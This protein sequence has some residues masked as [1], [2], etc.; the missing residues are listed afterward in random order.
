MSDGKPR[1]GR[2]SLQGLQIKHSVSLDTKNWYQTLLLRSQHG[3]IALH[4]EVTQSE[5]R[6]VT[7]HQCQKGFAVLEVWKCHTYNT[8]DGTR[9]RERH[10]N[11]YCNRKYR[12]FILTYTL[13]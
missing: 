9:E 6:K 2:T 12:T 3:L 13:T 4:Y 5:R 8:L 1:L 11:T 7:V 10:F